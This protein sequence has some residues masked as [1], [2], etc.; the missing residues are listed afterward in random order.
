MGL[1]AGIADHAAGVLDGGHLREVLGFGGVLLM[2]AAAEVGDFGQFRNVRRGVV[3]M[4][5]SGP[6]H[7]SQATW[8][9]LP[10]ARALASSS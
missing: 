1:V 2:A 4:L 8:A 3:R 7:A 6:W 9:C 5:A 10:A